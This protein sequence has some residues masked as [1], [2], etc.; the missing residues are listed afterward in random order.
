MDRGKEKEGCIKSTDNKN[1]TNIESEIVDIFFNKFLS[2]DALPDE[3]EKEFIISMKRK[4]H[5]ARKM[6]IQISLVTLKRLISKL[7]FG[8]GNDGLHSLF[9]ANA[10]D[11]FLNRLLLLINGWFRHCYIPNEV[12][13]GIINPRVKDNKGNIT[14]DGNYRPVMQSSS[15]LKIIELHLLK[16]CPKKYILIRDNL[17]IKQVCL[18]LMLASC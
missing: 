6:Y 2:G 9:L 8:S 7:K 11:K 14:V 12:L 10:S 1:G 17:A 13:K 18:Q 5:T 16:Y 3:R 4:W 15:V